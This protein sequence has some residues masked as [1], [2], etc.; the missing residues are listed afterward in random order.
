MKGDYLG[1][2]EELVLLAVAALNDTAYTT[3]IQRA[4]EREAHRPVSLGAVHTVLER[5]EKKGLLSSSPTEPTRERGGRRR[6]LFSV[7]KD[8][9]DAL[10]VAAG[11]RNRLT[12]LKAKPRG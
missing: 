10:S 6:R 9:R 7:S 1:A 12:A 5:L 3:S 4:L 2:F 11:L 8:G